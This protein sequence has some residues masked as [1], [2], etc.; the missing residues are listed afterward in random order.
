M[1]GNA[2]TPSP[3][4]RL[5]ESGKSVL[6]GTR[7]R[8]EGYSSRAPQTKITQHAH[9]AKRKQKKVSTHTRCSPRYPT[10]T[11]RV[12]AKTRGVRSLEDLYGCEEICETSKGCMIS[13]MTPPRSHPP[14][15]RNLSAPPSILH[16]L[17]LLHLGLFV[18]PAALGIA[19]T[20]TLTLP[21][22]SHD[23]LRLTSK[24]LSSLTAREKAVSLVS[25]YVATGPFPTF[26]LKPLSL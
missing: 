20:H 10:S 2:Y 3:P 22:T 14:F 17:H 16:L 26:R 18:Q 21:S 15:L 1:H 12:P 7:R 24:L 23:P 6:P 25:L 9:D 19:I 5:Q 8:G 13:M 11:Q 4:P